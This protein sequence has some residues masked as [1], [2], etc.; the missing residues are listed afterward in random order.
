MQSLTTLAY[1]YAAQRHS[2]VVPDVVR[3]QLY[4]LTSGRMIQVL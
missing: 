4:Y 1:L 2:D 3:H